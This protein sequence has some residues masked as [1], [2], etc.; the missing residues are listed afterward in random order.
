MLSALRRLWMRRRDP[1]PSPESLPRGLVGLNVRA[2][3]EFCSRLGISVIPD[4]LRRYLTTYDA[5]SALVIF[6]AQLGV[7]YFELTRRVEKRQ[8]HLARLRVAVDLILS[9]EEIADS[10]SLSPEPIFASLASSLP[11]AER[12]LS[13]FTDVA[14]VSQAI[15]GA[16]VVFPIHRLFKESFHRELNTWPRLSS[17]AVAEALEIHEA[18]GRLQRDFEAVEAELTATIE[19]L[20]PLVNPSADLWAICRRMSEEKDALEASILSGE[21][22]P[23]DGIAALRDLLDAWEAVAGEVEDPLDRHRRVLGVSAAATRAEITSAF[24]RLAFLYHP[25]RNSSRKAAATFIAIK[26]AYE[27]LLFRERPTEACHV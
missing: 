17:A 4:L 20:R 7:S 18:Y 15:S 22:A 26:E 16:V 25:D 8:A 14:R 19:R 6:L 5:R 24:R 27:A 23:A 13:H 2:G 21:T 3:E 11:R 1:R 9:A 12:L 10:T